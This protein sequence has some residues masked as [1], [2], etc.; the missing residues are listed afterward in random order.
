MK[1]DENQHRFAVAIFDTV[2][3]LNDAIG[4]LDREGLGF[5]RVSCLGL[6]PVLKRGRIESGLLP[7]VSIETL[8]FQA[9]V[10][11]VS[12]T[13]GPIARFLAARVSAGAQTLSSALEHWLIPRHASH[14][15]DAVRRGGIVMWVHIS[16]GELER[17]VCR[18]LL[19]QSTTSV[20]VHD[21]AAR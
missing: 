21:L 2:R 1:R 8:S 9:E 16:D 4:Q 13:V 11:D 10:E 15:A 14:I 7:P 18:C 12:C 20:G 3:S 6:G 5:E 19:T 17:R